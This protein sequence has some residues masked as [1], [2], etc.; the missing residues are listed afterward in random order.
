MSDP[1]TISFTTASEDETI[2]LG[3]RLGARLRPTDVVALAGELGAGKTRFVRGVAEG[4]GIDAGLVASPTFVIAHEYPGGRLGLVHIDASRLASP[5]ELD[6]I[7]WD[8]LAD[9]RRPLIIEWPERLAPRL[10]SGCA[11]ITIEHAGET[12]R[13]IR[14]E[15]DASLLRG[16]DRRAPTCRTC[17]GAV[18]PDAPSAPFCS[19]RCRM[20]DLSKWFGGAYTISRPLDRRDLEDV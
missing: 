16:L 9:G 3:A 18:D 7:G 13:I 15:G 17:G 4:L 6:A 2:A 19:E 11:R 8:T 10:P 1:I 14:L 12:T 20:A 5:D